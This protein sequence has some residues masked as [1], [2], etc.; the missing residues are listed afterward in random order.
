[1]PETA[2]GY[3]TRMSYILGA[4]VVAIFVVLFIFTGVWGGLVWIVV[5]GVVAAVVF[6][7]SALTFRRTTPGPTG[8]PRAQ[9][10]PGTANER[11][12]QS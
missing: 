1:V 2:A 11:V 4:V 3:P 9:T 12:G 10:A 7:G 5:A 6:A 8:K